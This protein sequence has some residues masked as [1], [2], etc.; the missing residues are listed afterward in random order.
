MHI[1]ISALYGFVVWLALLAWASIAGAPGSVLV[2]L[3]V[4]PLVVSGVA[5]ALI[6]ACLAWCGVRWL[7]LC[8]GTLRLRRSR[9]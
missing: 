3:L 1:A 8:M 7:W 4:A 9:A 6:A 5:L 2:V